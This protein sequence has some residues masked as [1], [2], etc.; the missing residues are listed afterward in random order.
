MSRTKITWLGHA[1]IK[2]E[3]DGK[4]VFFDPWIEGNP[5]CRIKL[6]QIR[7]ADAVCVTHGHIDHIGDSLAIVKTTKAPLVCSPEIGMYA[8]K[9]GGIKYDE[10]SMCLNIGGS[11]ETKAFT[12]TMVNAAHTSDIMGEDY[13]REGIV[14]AGSGSV[15]YVIEFKNGP[16]IYYGGDTGVF[17][18]MAIIRDL[19]SPD[20][21]VLPVGGKYNMGYRE[22][23]YAASLIHPK[24]FLPIHYDTFPNQRMDISK[25][26]REMKFRAPHVTVVRWK[27]GASFD[28]K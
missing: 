4:V 12:I 3:S 19:Y 21:A 24:Y 15:G 17:G 13:K 20:V 6:N 9:F 2:V 18:D 10:G 5:A 28:Y 8:E 23:G 27:P 1:S 14:T 26:E 16:S 7:K 25:L 22:A 11:W